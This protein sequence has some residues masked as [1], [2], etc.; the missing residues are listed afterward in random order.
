MAGGRARTAGFH[1]G[2]A[3][4]TSI[5]EMVRKQHRKLAALAGNARVA[6]WRLPPSRLIRRPAAGQETPGPPVLLW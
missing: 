1:S 6:V 5:M 3:R 2:L 4:H